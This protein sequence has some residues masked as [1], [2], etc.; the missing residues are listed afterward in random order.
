MKFE[1]AL[2][3]I[4]SVLEKEPH[5]SILVKDTIDALEPV[6]SIFFIVVNGVEVTQAMQYRHAAEHL[7]DPADRGPD[8]S[9]RL[10]ADKPAYVRVYVQSS[11][12]NVM[13][14]AG[15]VMLQ[16]RRYG[17]WVDAVPLMQQVPFAI[18]ALPDPKYAEERGSLLNSLNFIIP[19]SLMKGRMRLKVHVEVPGNKKYMA[20]AEVE[21][22]A[23]LK[24]TLRLRG[25]PV[26][27]WG[28]GA[29]GN[30]VKLS[31]PSLGDF[32]RTLATTLLMFPVSQTPNITLAGTFT[33]SEPLTGAIA[34][35]ACPSSWNNLLFWLGI[36]K[37]VDGNKSN[38]V[39]YGLLPSGIPVGGA[40]G[41]GGGGGTAAGFIDDGIAMA[42]EIGHYFNF[43]HAPGCLPA[44]DLLFDTNYPA[45]EP[46]DTVANKM[47][48]IGEYGLDPTTAT[49]YSPAFSSDIMSYCPSRWISLYHYKALI[50]HPLLDPQYVS[51]RGT[52]LPPYVNE[53]FRD[54]HRIPDPTPPWEYEHLFKQEEVQLQNYVVLTG[55]IK[56]DEVEIASVLRI[57]TRFNNTGHKLEGFTAEALDANNRV[58][59]KTPLRYLV[60][61]AHCGCGCSGGDSDPLGV[62]QA[63]LPS[64][65]ESFTYRIRHKENT[66]W[67]RQSSG[68]RFEVEHVNAQIE[69]DELHISWHTLNAGNTPFERA[70]MYAVN[71]AEEWQMLAVDVK[72]DK[73]SVRLRAVPTGNIRL[74]VMATNGFYSAYGQTS[75]DIP[76]AQPS[77]AILW[78]AEGAVVRTD[79]PVRFWG[80]ASLSNGEAVPEHAL[81]WELDG[82]PVGEGSEH[83]Q[84]LPEADSEHK[85]TLKV[86]GYGQDNET[87]VIFL[88]TCCG[89][90]PYLYNRY[91]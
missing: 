76:D 56:Y 8:N 72:E 82:R 68:S 6:R 88:A 47:A 89:R 50:E 32:Q 70:V 49:I 62:V 77:V 25:I 79:R 44:D 53:N 60:T 65:E 34:N 55:F 52:E 31:A 24:Q 29:S 41:C 84:E 54:P 21:I 23:S 38:M 33:F 12:V 18:T 66:L 9:V 81:Q 14:V 4:L 5:R 78:P 69:R 75:I 46:Y 22:N 7:T 35:G 63:I 28:P 61:Y 2:S 39:Y 71:N 16:V 40:S 43:P 3:T 1:K 87:S 83:W 74:K 10:V 59:H 48:S 30:Q 42:H 85:V 17:V 11:L 26:Q 57:D 36:A 64:H 27:Y 37:V 51:G 80:T 19:A 20:D 73:L 67:T 58:L 13:N 90:R 86:K 45:Y 15:S 91:D